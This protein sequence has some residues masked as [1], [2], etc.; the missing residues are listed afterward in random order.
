MYT[1]VSL[2]VGESVCKPRALVTIINELY[3]LYDGQVLKA[4]QDFTFGHNYWL[5]LAII[6]TAK[7]KD[8][9]LP[10]GLTFAL[11]RLTKMHKLE[12]KKISHF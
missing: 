7:L 6:P 3:K 4:D 9:Q 8:N 10:I 11:E 12:A 5:I 1:H 2:I